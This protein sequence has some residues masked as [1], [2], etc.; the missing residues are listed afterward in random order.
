MT[1]GQRILDIV[2]TVLIIL[3]SIGIV[4]WA[5]LF[6][7]SRSSS[8]S[9]F[10]YRYYTVI[11]PSMEPTYKVGDVV[12]VKLA[13]ADEIKVD[14]VIT[15]NPSSDPDTYLTHRVTEVLPNYQ[16]S[17]VT[18]FKTKGDANDTEDSF[19]IDSGRLIGRVSFRIPKVGYLIRFLQLYWY[20]AIP[21]LILF[22]IMLHMIRIYVSTSDDDEPEDEGHKEEKRAETKESEKEM[23][24][25][26][27][28]IRPDPEDAS[29]S[30]E[31]SIPSESVTAESATAKSVASDSAV[32]DSV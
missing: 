21:L 17:G 2:R 29:T 30:E 23:E 5:I 11:T 27:E 3:L 7:V 31:A 14:D 1:K 13:N 15:F 26:K 25:G 12:I 8:K 28:K 22:I 20:L 19:I 16:G 6:A 24:D 4:I 9:I 10:G 18:C 32:S